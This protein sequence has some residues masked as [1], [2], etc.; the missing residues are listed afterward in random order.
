MNSPVLKI[1]LIRSDIEAVQE[2][3]L[4]TRDGRLPR[5]DAS[6]RIGPAV[7]AL[8]ARFID[9]IIPP[10]LA[11]LPDPSSLIDG[12]L[13]GHIFNHA[14][15]SSMHL[16]PLLAWLHG[17]ALKARLIRALEESDYV[18]GVP[19]DERP[20]RLAEL[21]EHLRRLE[22]EEEALVEAAEAA[23]LEVYRRPDLDWGIVL[24]YD[25]AG[26]MAVPSAAPGQFIAPAAPPAASDQVQAQSASF[27]G[28]V[29]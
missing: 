27:L 18:A 16:G 10:N 4:W 22:T 21:N 26:D 1:D 29:L 5:D 9:G 13:T 11:A 7:D 17:D 15:P 24:E 23:G 14:M 8:A 3:I 25:P 2:E 20:G 6:A 19:L 28:S 12:W